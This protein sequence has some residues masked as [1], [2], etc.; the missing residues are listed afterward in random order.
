MK[1]AIGKMIKKARL[2]RNM[3]QMELAEALGFETPQFVSL[4]ER[5][6]SK[7]PVEVLGRLVVILGI[8]ERAVVKILVNRYTNSVKAEIGKGKSMERNGK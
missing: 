8:N 2:K 4:M 6:L 7:A 5:G 3:T 1:Y